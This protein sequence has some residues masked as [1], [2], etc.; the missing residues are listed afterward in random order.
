MIPIFP[1]RLKMTAFAPLARRLIALT[2]AIGLSACA[3]GP[4][5]PLMSPLSPGG[6]YGYTEE[7]LGD[8]RLRVVYVTPSLRSSS[9]PARRE[10]DAASLRA[11]AL[12]LA[13]WR[14]AERALDRGFPAF[15]IEDREATVEVTVYGEG[16]HF[17]DRY[18][19]HPRGTYRIASHHVMPWAH[20]TWVQARATLTVRF[21]GAPAEGALDARATVERM[22][23]KRPE[24]RLPPAF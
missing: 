9:I 5:P 19:G 11:L 7:A 8:G 18:L 4:Q 2:F 6:E 3:T 24:G 12:D 21:L 13:T 15:R 14:A 20:S 17:P 10:A 1:P 16:P 23:R 22:R